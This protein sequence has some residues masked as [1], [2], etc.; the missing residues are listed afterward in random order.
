[1]G[2]VKSEFTAYSLQQHFGVNG[3]NMKICKILQQKKSG[4]KILQHKKKAEEQH[5]KEN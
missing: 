2:A 5:E 4:C 1:V 3:C